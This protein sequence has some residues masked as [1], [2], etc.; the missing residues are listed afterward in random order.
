[1]FQLVSDGGDAPVIETTPVLSEYGA[2]SPVLEK[3]R[4]LYAFQ[5][6]GKEELP[7]EENEELEILDKPEEDPEWWVARN[8]NGAIGLVPRIYTEVLENNF[9]GNKKLL[10]F[11]IKNLN[12]APSVSKYGEIATRPWFHEH[13]ATRENAENELSTAR[14]G[15]FIVRPSE[16]SK[17]VGNFSVSVRGRSKTKHF[18]VRQEEGEYLIGQRKFK[19]LDTLI[20]N[21]MKN[22]IFSNGEERLN[23]VR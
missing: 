19:D 4:C 8:K 23:L 7:F 14:E 5:G 21:Y 20:Q 17:D 1:M 22:P 12:L 6:N 13:C 2:S 15:D 11:D 18:R 9:P 16:S 3:V 10:Y